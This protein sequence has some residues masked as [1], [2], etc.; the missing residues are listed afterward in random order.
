MSLGAA[1]LKSKES[2]VKVG[3]LVM[4]LGTRTIG[5]V[6]D[7]DLCNGEAFVKWET[8]NAWSEI[9]YLEVIR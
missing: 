6:V 9:K 4:Q 5:L 8:Y 1:A 3:D 2:S 7:V